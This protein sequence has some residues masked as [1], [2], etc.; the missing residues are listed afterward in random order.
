MSVSVILMCFFVVLFYKF[1]LFLETFLFILF[2]IFSTSTEMYLITVVFLS[3]GNL[4]QSG[5]LYVHFGKCT[6]IVVNIRNLHNVHSTH[7]TV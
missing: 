3:F 5:L 7:T 6:T 2:F 1:Y 4:V